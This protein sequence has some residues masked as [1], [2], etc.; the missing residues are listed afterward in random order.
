M[1]I[2]ILEDKTVVVINI[3][4]LQ[5][6]EQNF[7]DKNPTGG[8]KLVDS[9]PTSQYSKWKEVDGEI[10]V[11]E[12]AETLVKQEYIN[13]ENRNYLNSTDWYE[14]RAISGKLVPEDILQKRQEARDSIVEGN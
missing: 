14:I 9:L 6:Q 5:L 4:I 2:R 11:D 12:E 8:F 10:V 13:E 1:I 3:G 7:L